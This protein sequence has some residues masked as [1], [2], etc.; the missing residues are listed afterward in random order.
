LRSD[1]VLSKYDLTLFMS[2]KGQ[3]IGGL[4]RYSA[5]LFEAGTIARICGRFETLL[6]SIAANPDAHLDSLEM[7]TEAER[8]RQDGEKRERREARAMKLRSVRRESVDL[9][10]TDSAPRA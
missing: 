7:L 8:Q 9:G 10:D 4:W 1:L 6:E 3:S 2:D 5:E